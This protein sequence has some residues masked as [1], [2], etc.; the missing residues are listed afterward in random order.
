MKLSELIDIQKLHEL[1]AN[2]QDMF[3]VPCRILDAD[4]PFPSPGSR[5]T[6]C[7]KHQRMD[8][9]KK[10][11]A[12]WE[13]IGMSLTK[14]KPITS[15]C[16]MGLHD[17]ALPVMIDGLLAGSI[18][19]GPFRIEEPDRDQVAKMANALGMDEE[20]LFREHE[21][22][23]YIRPEK[24]PALEK[25]LIGIAGLIME[26][27][28]DNKQLAAAEKELRRAGTDLEKKITERTAELKETERRLN[29]AQH[30][31]KTGSFQQNLETGICWW[32][33][34]MYRQLGYEIN[35]QF[36]S[37]ENFLERLHPEEKPGF[38]ELMQTSIAECRNFDMELRI[39]TPQ[40][41]ERWFFAQFYVDCRTP[42][43]AFR[44]R[45][46]LRNITFRKK[47]EMELLRVN[48][49]QQRILDN[50]ILGI[51][52]L[53]NRRF[54]WLNQRAADIARHPLEEMIG[55]STR[56]VHMDEKQYTI[57]KNA[58]LS[59]F[60]S[61][62]PYDAVNQFKGADGS[63]FW[64]RTV[65]S[66][67]DWDNPEEGSIWLIED[68]TARQNAQRELVRSRQE[69]QSIFNNSQVGIVML[70]NGRV[71]ARA[72]RR[73]AEILGYDSAESMLGKD[74]REIHISEEAYREFGETYYPKLTEGELS[75][76]EYQLRR[77]DGSVVWC[78]LSGK[79]MDLA[80]PPDLDKGV[81]WIL[82]DISKRKRA[83]KALYASERRFRAIFNH[84]GVGIC[85]LNKDG[86]IQ[87]I[88][89]RMSMLVG[90]S[91][92]DLVGM[93]IS[94]VTHEDDRKA[95]KDLN[96]RLWIRDI[97]MY[98]REKRY[99]RRDGTEVWG[100]VT[101]TIVHDDENSPQYILQV[102]ENIHERK[103]LEAELLR[104]AKTDALTGVNNRYS[105]LEHSIKEF[106]RFKRY[107][108]PCSVLLLDVD[109]FKDINDTYG[110]MAGDTVL[111]ALATTCVSILRSTD[112]FGRMGG[113]EFAALLVETSLEQ[114]YAV[115]E[116]M[117]G[118][119]EELVVPSDGEDIRFT[120]SIG[121]TELQPDDKTLE[122]T[123]HRADELM[124][125]A[126]AQGRNRVIRG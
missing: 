75:Q 7:A 86:L 62:Q 113:E 104:M 46:A 85:T 35:E 13:G 24:I 22:A 54:V 89:N 112:I 3:D 84:A 45:G 118:A 110:H 120:V 57:T 30:I 18:I 53:R 92:Y 61:G 79:A 63:S 49:L 107:G 97:P 26:L 73:L 74:I 102:T 65:A 31:A 58:S 81:I 1:A 125:E 103:R 34:E 123:Q 95:D 50:S 109:H 11:Q 44:I 36:C 21:A 47:I 124:Y 41:R 56:M 42:G 32:S 6:I 69:L 12:R 29:D 60:A 87:R 115:A 121:V 82:E 40:S 66:P 70:Q 100:R 64:C 59:L 111:K 67:L 105:F 55:S 8:S 5:K 91:D 72:N 90:Y 117:R 16:P 114:A 80:S 71:I 52:L 37:L 38:Q 4:T 83:E 9:G 15:R 20:T 23:P 119:I 17:M 126:K 108:T 39:I 99:V 96:S 10:C 28:K 2:F 19:V 33:D 43:E 101:T 25:Y 76:I 51:A 14:G 122:R 48:R 77:K 93:N 68:V 98:V 106:E 116:R 78:A 27:G 88:N 94:E